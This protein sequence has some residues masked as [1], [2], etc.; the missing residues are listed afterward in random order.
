M[1]V[2]KASGRGPGSEC[3][4]CFFYYFL[5]RPSVFGGLGL[6]IWTGL[7]N[8]HHVEVLSVFFSQD[9][10]GEECRFFE[11][12]D[13][14]SLTTNLEDLSRSCEYTRIIYLYMNET[15][16]F[17]NNSNTISNTFG[18]CTAIAILFS[19]SSRS[20]FGIMILTNDKERNRQLRRTFSQD[21]QPT[22]SFPH[23]PIC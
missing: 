2:R 22:Q 19:I 1:L 9:F 7:L 11:W 21:F 18:R 17:C 15:A 10:W 16:F 14:I 3:S 13:V 5:S 12:F 6:A 20:L 4:F 8:L 23:Q